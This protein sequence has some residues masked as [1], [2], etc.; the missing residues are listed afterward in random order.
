MIE[1]NNLNKKLSFGSKNHDATK[2]A[3]DHPLLLKAN[4]RNKQTGKCT[5]KNHKI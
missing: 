5:Y 4:K 2:C 1:Q 3:S